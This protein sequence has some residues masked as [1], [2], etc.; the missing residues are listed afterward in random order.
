LSEQASDL[1]SSISPERDAASILAKLL[2]VFKEPGN[3]VQVLSAQL[4]LRR[5]RKVP[6]TTRLRGRVAVENRGTIELGKRVRIDGRTVR[7]E[8]ACWQNAHMTIGAGTFLNYGVSLSA[9]RELTI[10]K[11]CLIGNYVTIM[12][13]DYHDL[14]DHSL[15]GRSEP[16]H[17]GDGVWIG[18]RSVILKGVTLGDGCV[19]GAGS[20]V[21]SDVPAKSVAF[22]V[23]ARVIRS[24]D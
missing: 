23:P 8:L 16:I 17:I 9:H 2:R 12:D 19:I 1:V 6:L 21:T 20:V 14:R 10:G 15:P 22:G 5:C 3:A 13:N 24:L 7:V 11:D 4:N 18:I